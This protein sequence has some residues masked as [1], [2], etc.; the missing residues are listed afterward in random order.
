MGTT[1][2]QAGVASAVLFCA[3]STAALGQQSQTTLQAAVA[4][5]GP[6]VHAQSPQVNTPQ[7][8]GDR[9][10]SFFRDGEWYVEYGINKEYWSRSDIHVS[11]PGLGNNFTLYNV[12]G[13]DE[14]CCESEAFTGNLFGPQYNIRVGRFITDNIGVEFSL[15]HTK[16]QSTIG[17]VARV[18]GTA[19]GAPINGN[20]TLDNTFFTETLHNG[21]NHVMLNAI[22]RYPLIGNINDTLSLSAIGK[23]GAG[24]MIP[25]TSDAIMGNPVDVGSKSFS[26]SFGLN[27]GWWQFNGV[28]AGVEGGF[29]LVLY[30]P[31]YVELTDKVAY[32]YF[33][34]LPVFMGTM[35]QS[36][37]M[38]EAIVTLGFTYDGTGR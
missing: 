13:H 22:Y 35:K 29:R 21:A 9:V 1:A 11:Q 5:A 2:V 33:G 20:F 23:A 3:A 8:F 10:W 26:N 14:Q 15:D 31:V 17:Q 4:A 6:S 24:L 19:G 7:S 28:T 38:N 25:H 36:L 34:D 30:K 32:S 18:Q 27:R 12:Q 16:Y 37:W